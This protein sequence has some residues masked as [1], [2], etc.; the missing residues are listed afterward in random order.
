M[1]TASADTPEREGRFAGRRVL[2]L[3]TFDSFVKTAAVIGRMFESEGASLKILALSASEGQLTTRQLEANGVFE[4]VDVVAAETLVKSRLF[5]DAHVVIAVVDGGRA[6]ELF[7]ALATADLSREPARP[8]VV[9]A[10]P[11]VVLAD[12]LAGF[13]SRAPADV[14]CF[15]TDGDRDLYRAAAAELGLDSTNALVTGLLGLDRRLWSPPAKKA[16]VFFEQPVIPAIRIQRTHLL[17]S[18]IDLATRFPDTDVLIKLR[19]ARDE[20]AHHS[21]RFHLEDLAR[22]LFARSRRPANLQFTHEPAQ[23]LVDRASLVATVSSTIAVEAMARGA[24]TRIISDFGVSEALG[25]TYFVGSGCFATLRE[26][27]PE[28][29]SAVEPVWLAARSGAAARP[30]PMLDQVEALLAGQDRLEA[31]LPL[32][33]LTPAYGSSDWMAFAL[34]RGGPAAVHA[35]HLVEKPRRGLGMV[36]AVA[37]RLRQVRRPAPRG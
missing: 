25:T 30:E 10:S 20:R 1:S 14:L 16:I 33:P 27:T 12:H 22:E 11:G 24:P 35:P 9:V 3:G 19:H 23:Q 28:M 15:N 31:A 26:L 13:M 32:R 29:G 7:L 18:L 36:A 37:R 8:I 34:G 6:R 2:A 4:S 17:A 5:R 21:A